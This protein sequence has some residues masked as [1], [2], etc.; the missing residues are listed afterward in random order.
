MP[1]SRTLCPTHE[2]ILLTLT[3]EYIHNPTTFHHPHHHHLV[4]AA[5]LSQ[6]GHLN[7]LLTTKLSVPPSLLSLFSTVA[8]VILLK[9]EPDH[10][11]CLL[12]T[13]Q[14][15][16][17]HAIKANIL[18]AVCKTFTNFL[19]IASLTSFS[20]LSGYLIHSSH[21]SLLAVS[22]TFQASVH[23]ESLHQLPPLLRTPFPDDPHDGLPCLLRSNVSAVTLSLMPL[24][25]VK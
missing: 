18:R 10:I 7:S 24:P 13:R 22:Q 8:S 4:L 9:H 14:W 6:L 11:A 5:I 3:S 16:L 19:L 23:L 12:R 25:H 2:Q 15:L 21:W 17:S 20:P 1:F